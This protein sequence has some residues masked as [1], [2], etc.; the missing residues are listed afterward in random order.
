MALPPSQ[1][2]YYRLRLQLAEPPRSQVQP[3]WLDPLPNINPWRG[4]L[5][6]FAVIHDPK[7]EKNMENYEKILGCLGMRYQ[8]FF[9]Y[10]AAMV[11]KGENSGGYPP[12]S[13]DNPR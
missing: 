11:I 2:D 8:I 13:M 10:V 9:T 5:H 1:S 4:F 3:A 7:P 6:F 12:G